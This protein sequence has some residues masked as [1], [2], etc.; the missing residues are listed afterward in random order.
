MSPEMTPQDVKTQI[1]KARDLARELHKGQCDISEVGQALKLL[2]TYR[3]LDWTLKLFRAR[4]QYTRFPRSKREM[5]HVGQ[6]IQ[7]LEQIQAIPQRS[8]QWKTVLLA[9]VFRSLNTLGR[10][11][12]ERRSGGD[13]QNRGPRGRPNNRGRGGPGGKGRRF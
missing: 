11:E 1:S 7:V 3:N 8:V 13:H 12:R 10:E 5:E 4:K 6:V 2:S 9:R